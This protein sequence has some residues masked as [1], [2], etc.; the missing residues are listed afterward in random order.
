[1]RGTIAMRQRILAEA[2]VRFLRPARTPLVV[3]LPYDWIPPASTSFFSG[4]DLDW[5]DLASVRDATA[6]ADAE[7]VATDDLLY[8]ER[9]IGF[10]LDN[11]NFRAAEGLR[12]AGQTIDNLLTFNDAIGRTVADQALTA[13]SYAARA[14]PD[15]A[16]ASTERSR[17]WIQDRLEDVEVSTPRA[18]TLSSINGSFPTSI[19][20]TLDETVTVSLAARS[21]DDQLVISA[22]TE[23][24]IPARGSK[25]VLLDARTDTP[26]VHDVTVLVTDNQGNALGG[27]DELSVRSARVSNIIW[28]FLA[29]G[30]ALLFGT[31]GVRLVRR[32]RA[33]RR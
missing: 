16:R 22:P 6:T 24:E 32:V 13:T 4:L 27:A 14:R 20:N 9:Q 8:P 31:I 15:S 11:A 30:I 19:T 10:E 18:V 23:V 25:T 3:L 26:G 21:E 33:A 2:A 12:Q 5:I 7:P 29:T 28:L 17:T 1:V